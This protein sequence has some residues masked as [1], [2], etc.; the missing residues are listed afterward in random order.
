MEGR[1]G[2]EFGGTRSCEGVSPEGEG[3][4]EGGEDGE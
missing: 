1:E 4:G 3:G 2:E